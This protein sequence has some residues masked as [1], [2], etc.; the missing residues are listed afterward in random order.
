M[1]QYLSADYKY[2]HVLS[3]RGPRQPN[4]PNRSPTQEV[5]GPRRAHTCFLVQVIYH[6]NSK[7]PK[8]QLGEVVNGEESA[9]VLGLHCGSY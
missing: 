4:Y 1:M 5:P 8:Q 3:I 2:R 9:P 7:N 6:Y